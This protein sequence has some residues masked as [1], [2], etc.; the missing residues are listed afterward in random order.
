VTELEEIEF[1]VGV[2]VTIRLLERLDGLDK[3]VG[4]DEL[5]T[6]LVEVEA[7]DFAVDDLLLHW[8]NPAWQPSP[9]Y[10]GILPQ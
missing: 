9:Q 8:P 2:G 7:T 3:L 10:A 1:D 5:W 4:F 6:E